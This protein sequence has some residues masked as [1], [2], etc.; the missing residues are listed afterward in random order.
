MSASHEP[1]TAGRADDDATLAR[2]FA[3][4]DPFKLFAEW[5]ADAEQS[6]PRDHNAMSLA[7]VDDDGA[8]DVRVVLLKHVDEQ[9]FVFY[10][11]TLS[12]KGRQLSAVPRA[13]L[14]F[15]WKSLGRQV[16]VRGDVSPVAA[17]EADAYFASRPRDSRI[18]AWASAQSEPLES[19]AVFEA[20]IAAFERKFDGGEPPR[21]P[22]WS[23]Y[24]LA[25]RAIEF[26]HERAFRLHDRRKFTRAPGEA[27]RD[28]RLFP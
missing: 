25:P 27:W 4:P 19:R 10:T 26:W 17:A 1:E 7:T 6:E 2:M 28:V 24:R 14:C 13:A 15:Y 3:E 16:R 21:P 20:E 23:G 8:P 5:L 11:N 22:H 18:G 12:A 9:G